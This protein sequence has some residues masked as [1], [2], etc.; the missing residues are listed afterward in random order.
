M[1][2]SKKSLIALFAV[3]ILYGVEA[4]GDAFVINN[5][6][7]TAY[8]VTYIDGGPPTV[9]TRPFFSLSGSGLSIMS[10]FPPFGGGDPGNVEARDT[11]IINPCTPGM[12][13]GT[14]SSFAGTIAPGDGGRATVN[15]VH[16]P[17]VQHTGTLD[18]VSSPIVI[19]NAPG[20]FEV[21]IPFTFSGELSGNA[22]QPGIT[23]PIFTAALSGQGRATFHFEDTS[24]GI[25]GP[26]YRLS[27]IEYRFGA[28]P[29]SIDI[30]PG[31]LLNT[32]NP[33]SKGKVPVA[34]LSTDTF[35]ATTVDPSTVL[36]GAT[37]SE[38]EPVH[39]ALEDV[40]G[41]GDIDMVLHFVTQDTGITCGDSDASL[42]GA[43]FSGVTVEGSDSIETVACN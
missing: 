11:C 18:F 5:V 24:H 36:F 32:I 34:I 38:A 42:T 8:V 26:R 20:G 22:W 2:N 9:R 43:T 10:T 1:F 14:N 39:S 35:D 33:K 27:F 12:V 41:D 3:F 15:G 13:I 17:F 23:N 25:G 19:L 30:K 4:R 29:I 40:D 16:Y 37:G 28:Y 31:T 7:G 6:Q 21:T